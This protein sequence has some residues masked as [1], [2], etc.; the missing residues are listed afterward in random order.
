MNRYSLSSD[1]RFSG[2]LA[3][4]AGL[5][6]SGALATTLVIVPSG[7]AAAEPWSAWDS[8]PGYVHV[9]LDDV[10][11]GY[12][13]IRGH[14]CLPAPGAECPTLRYWWRFVY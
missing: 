1:S 2:F 10:Q 12:A 6:A 5:A 4:T 14:D 8:Q 13:H 9:P 3:A 7:G 11:R